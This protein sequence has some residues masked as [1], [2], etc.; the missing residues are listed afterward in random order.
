MIIMTM[1]K[2]CIS[3]KQME[4]SQSYIFCP[5]FSTNVIIAMVL[6][7]MTV[8]VKHVLYLTMYI[9]NYKKCLFSLLKTIQKTAELLEAHIYDDVFWDNPL[10]GKTATLMCLLIKDR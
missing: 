5:I 4:K 6:F 7:V 8:M 10:S 2:V 9:K 1:F 3:V